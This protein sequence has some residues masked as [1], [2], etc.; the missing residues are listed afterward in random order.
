MAISY[1][2]GSFARAQFTLQTSGN[3]TVD[4][5]TGNG[6]LVIA[7]ALIRDAAGITGLS[8]T[9]GGQSMTQ[10]TPIGG[11]ANNIQAQIWYLEDAPSGSNQIAYSWSSDGSQFEAKGFA[12]SGVET[13]SAQDQDNA[14]TGTSDAPSLSVTPTEDNELI[15]GVIIHEDSVALTVGSGETSLDDNDNGAWVTSASYAI[16]GSATSQSVDWSAN[17]SE[18]YAMA[19]ATFKEGAVNTSPSVALDTADSGNFGQQPE[20]LFT[21]TD[22]EGDDIRYNIQ[23]SDDPNFGVTDGSNKT[24]SLETGSGTNIHPNPLANDTW[25]GYIMVDDRPGQVIQ[26]TGGILDKI[27][28][29]FGAHETSPENTDGTYL[30]HVYQADG[31]PVDPV[32]DAW[33]ATTAYSLN[34]YIRPT[35]TANADVHWLYQCTS[36]GTSDSTEPDWPLT[37]DETVDD[38]TVTWKAVLPGGPVNRQDVAV[39]TPTQ[40]WVAVSDLYPYSPGVTDVGWK[41]LTF[42]DENRIGLTADAWYCFILD[43]RPNDRENTNALITSHAS[44]ANAT[45]PGNS[46]LD[47]G[48]QNNLGPRIID[49][50]YYQLY[51]EF[52][53]L[54]KVSG[55]DNGFANED[56]PADTDPFTSGDQISFTVQS[57]DALTPGRTYYWRV[58]AID[59]AGSNTYGDWTSSRSFTVPANREPESKPD[60]PDQWRQGVKIVG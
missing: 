40:G 36:A 1:V 37:E 52:V 29:N 17:S 35:S 7:T 42:S 6:R 44:L 39:D 26:A 45:A 58:R 25:E 5:G 41:T 54:D 13:T 8:V 11:P 22:T 33:S 38:N 60:L 53:F 28:F 21:G 20:L 50:M 59:P 18:A 15:V 31:T 9:Y 32:P 57:G 16:Q 56:T 30:C 47:G 55:T 24:S 3:L 4:C 10:V 46:Y 23:I 34:E 14:G 12:F 51:E 49:D 19:V 48:T 2:S 43:W 27:Q